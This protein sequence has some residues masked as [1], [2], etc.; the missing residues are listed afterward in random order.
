MAPGNEATL[1]SLRDE[2][3]RPPSLR[4]P[5]PDHLVQHE[6]KT[7]FRLD[8]DK[9]LRNLRCARRGAPAGT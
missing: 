2:S 8:R 9:F 4:E 7:L 5:F 6:A 3:R 1:N